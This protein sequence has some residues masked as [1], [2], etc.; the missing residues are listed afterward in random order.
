[1]TAR[2]SSATG[3]SATDTFRSWLGVCAVRVGPPLTTFPALRTSHQYLTYYQ[4]RQSFQA[5]PRREPLTLNL[6][7]HQLSKY[8]RRR[9]HHTHQRRP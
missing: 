3:P 6:L 8:R 5:R 9:V 2:T 1:M 7:Y 4:H